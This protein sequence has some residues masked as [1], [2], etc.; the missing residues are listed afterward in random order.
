[1]KKII[2][3]FFLLLNLVVNAQEEK[4]VTLNVSGTGKTLEEAKINALRSAIEQAF[5]AF[6]SS[7]TEILNDNLVK[8]EIVSIANGNIQKF[9]IISQVEI[10]NN[11]YA[12]TLNATV[13]ISKLTS[14]AQ[15][16]GVV[17]EF[18]GGM[19]ALKI[20][21]QKLNEESEF[22]AIKNLLTQTFEILQSSIDYS[23]N[24]G[25]P[26][27]VSSDSYSINLEIIETKNS[28]YA[29]CWDYFKSTVSKI[30]LNDFEA[31]ELTKNGK[32]LCYLYL[33]NSGYRFRNEKSI[34][35]LFNFSMISSMLAS[36]TFFI[37]NNLGVVKIPSKI[38]KFFN[39]HNNDLPIDEYNKSLQFNVELITIPEQLDV[40]CPR[41]NGSFLNYVKTYGYNMDDFLNLDLT[42]GKN[43]NNPYRIIFRNDK[44]LKITTNFDYSNNEKKSTNYN[45]DYSLSEIKKIETFEIEKKPFEDLIINR[46]KYRI[47]EVQKPFVPKK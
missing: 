42:V 19:F 47:I 3:L 32:E 20:E 37:K 31:N 29:V 15:S 13:S 46:D 11:G 43:E 30:A 33:D 44:Y 5:G 14:F 23:I 34:N 16:K 25:E 8:D 35:A 18:K 7:K 6:I 10:P 4:T 22:K 45:L 21:L 12:M 40:K 41:F 36:N 27:L 38:A 28:N 2:I 26:N 39:S 17:V 24:V 9:D 1:M